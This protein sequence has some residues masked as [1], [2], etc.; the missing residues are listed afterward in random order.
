MR[1]VNNMKVLGVTLDPELRLEDFV[2]TMICKSYATLAGLAKF[3]KK[4]PTEVKKKL[5]VEALFSHHVMYCL[6]VWGGCRD[7]QRKRV[8][9]VPNLSCQERVHNGN[10]S[11][12]EG[13]KLS[14]PQGQT[15][16]MP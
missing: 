10:V 3:A 15:C 6:A 1:P 4:L 5:I 9:K 8:Q 12:S 13:C 11:R 2:S 7:S 16:S 14:P